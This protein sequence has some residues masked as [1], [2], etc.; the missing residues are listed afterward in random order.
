V[1]GIPLSLTDAT[2]VVKVGSLG[3][4]QEASL[5]P[6]APS[7]SPV[8]V[9]SRVSTVAILRSGKEAMRHGR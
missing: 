1:G 9:G 8:G 6:V 7:S 4:G 3:I 5:L 2:F